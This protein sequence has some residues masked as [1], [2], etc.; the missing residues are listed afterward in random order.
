MLQNEVAFF[1]KEMKNLFGAPQ[2][3]SSKLI[4]IVTINYNSFAD[5]IACIN[6]L[7]ES[8]YLNFN[9]VLIDNG[10]TDESVT[11]IINWLGKFSIH[12]FSNLFEESYK[13]GNA[14]CDTLRYSIL[15]YQSENEKIDCVK[16]ITES[17]LPA[18]YFIIS[19][20]NL[21]FAKA[22]NVGMKFA[23]QI[24]DPNYFWILNNDTVVDPFSLFEL[25]DYIDKQDELL[26]A[27]EF[28][29]IGSK[30]FYHDSPNILQGVG[31]KFN[32]FLCSNKLIGMN[33]KDHGQYDVDQ[34][35]VD[36]VIGA[37]MLVKRQFVKEVG[38]MNEDY[39]LYYEEIDW[40][41]RGRSMGWETTYAHKSK[42]YHKQGVST[43]QKK[44]SEE[45]TK[46]KKVRKRSLLLFYKMAYPNLLFIAIGRLIMIEIFKPN[47]PHAI[48]LK[49]LIIL[50]R[51]VLKN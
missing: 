51:S 10:S 39:F 13:E 21:G 26:P 32:R 16:S 2:P 12:P 37:S 41:T 44:N 45:Y 29:I 34:V 22:N 35:K 27:N 15:N 5:T 11:E 23:E 14:D 28:G 17:E 1:P 42:I 47:N 30:I 18:L 46:I 36:Y 25:I 31:A 20:K 50:T 6:S 48:G 40:C 43:G 4:S 19:D 8:E 33:E 49:E 9:I 3:L 7:I 38:Y 24:G